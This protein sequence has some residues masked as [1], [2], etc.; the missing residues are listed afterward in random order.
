LALSGC[1]L[2]YVH[3]QP[4]GGAR[5][6]LVVLAHGFSRTNTQM[7]G[8]A[9]HL[10]SWGLEVVVPNLC[11]STFIDSD[12]AQ[13]GADMVD[14]A[15]DLGATQ[16]IYMGH[17]AGGLA[18]LVAA[19]SDPNAVGLVGF[20]PVEDFFSTGSGYVGDVSVPTWAFFGEPG[21]CN[22]SGNG[23]DL[24]GSAG[25]TLLRI[26]EA[27]HCDFENETD[28]GCTSFCNYLNLT[29]SDS[30]IRSTILGF[31]TAAVL[32]AGGVESDTAE[33][34]SPG[35]VYYEALEASG[36]ISIP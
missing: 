34:V 8:W 7:L 4:G 10:S 23:V 33:W 5:G 24:Y 19:A 29:F 16:V 20:D 11:H 18:A 3:Y 14:L 36:A 15:N 13:N 28:F 35:G 6:P 30:Q 22:S 27:D 9:S 26:N 12:A 21:V 32:G 1:T 2:E 31:S 25:G 17:S